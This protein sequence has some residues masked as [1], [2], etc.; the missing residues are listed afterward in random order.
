MS[1]VDP[2]RTMASLRHGAEVLGQLQRRCAQLGDGP[3]RSPAQLG[4]AT[5]AIDEAIDACLRIAEHAAIADPGGSWKTAVVELERQ[6]RRLGGLRAQVL[7][8]YVTSSDYVKSRDLH[9]AS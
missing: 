8:L 4:A 2:Q 3:E 6:L 5:A 7:D 9:R 1:T